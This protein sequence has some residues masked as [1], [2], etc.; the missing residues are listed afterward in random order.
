MSLYEMRTPSTSGKMAMQLHISGSIVWTDFP[1]CPTSI[2]FCKIVR[3]LKIRETKIQKNIE[4]YYMLLFY[5]I[6]LS[7]TNIVFRAKFSKVNSLSRSN[8]SLMR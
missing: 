2:I 5:Y 6:T 8:P 7:Y 3:I 1:F 4:Q